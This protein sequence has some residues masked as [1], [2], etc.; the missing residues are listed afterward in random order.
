[1]HW[2]C[3]VTRIQCML[4][5]VLGAAFLCVWSSPVNAGSLYAIGRDDNDHSSHLYRIDDY[6]TNP[7]AV[8]ISD[9]NVELG[10]IAI[11]P[12]TGRAY[13]MSNAD[14]CVLYDLNLSTGALS[15]PRATGWADLVA[16]E[17]DVMGQ[18]YAWQNSVMGRVHKIDAATGVATPIGFTAPFKPGGDLAWDTDGT[19]YG[20]A[21]LS[22]LIRVDTT[23]GAGTFIGV[24]GFGASLQGLEIDDAGVMYGAG[25]TAGT[26]EALLYTISKQTGVATFVG[27]IDNANVIITGLA[28]TS[29]PEPCTAA[30]FMVLAAAALRRLRVA[31]HCAHSLR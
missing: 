2:S 26:G 9:T 30:S 27:D 25:P 22:T 31:R 12:T 17:F 4:L 14:N 11:D 3:S 10:D 20:A 24:T 18:M 19:M 16:L 7:R 5:V 1:M 6:A 15:A 29:V 28:F 21:D 8:H 13:A 23:T